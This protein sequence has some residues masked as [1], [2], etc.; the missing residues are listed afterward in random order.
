M[1][2]NL[3]RKI[4]MKGNLP[5]IKQ[6]NLLFLLVSFAILL[7]SSLLVPRLGI[8]VNLWINEYLWILAP[9][10]F[11]AKLGKMP[12]KEVFHLKKTSRRNIM[13]GMM[14]AVSLWFFAF[15]LSKQTGLFLDNK[16]GAFDTVI[17]NSVSP[18]QGILTL[19]G[20]LILAPIC[21]ELLF[22]GVIQS[23]YEAHN[24]KYGFVFSAIL[25]CMFH[26]M[27]GVTEVIPTFFVGLLLGYL[28]YR[29]G[30]IM[31]SMAAHMATNFSA[32]FING[33]L[34]LSFLKVI[35]LW[36]PIV[37]IVGLCFVAFLLSRL[38]IDEYDV[39][40]QETLNVPT[41]DILIKDV[42]IKEISIKEISIEERLIE[43][44]L[45]EDLPIEV[46]STKMKFTIGSVVLLILSILFVLCIGAIE[47]IAR[48]TL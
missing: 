3:E 39:I 45:I 26:V 40:D 42:P 37:S 14:A 8:G 24:K 4:I 23:A 12:T 43:E 20:M 18:S 30:S 29:T 2:N 31:A 1:E 32:L 36:L 21:E 48:Q 9:T 11:L 7:S 16:F 15:Y 33:S 17:T 47:I 34:G 10:V 46:I 13:I 25:F 41:K 5:S 27:S 6:A 44:K 22:R 28:V 19:I 38:K 35:P